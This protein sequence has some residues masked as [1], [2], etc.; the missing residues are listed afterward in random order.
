MLATSLLPGRKGVY[1]DVG[2]YHPSQSSNTYRL[3]LRGWSGVTI[4]PNP[5]A[6]PLFRRRRPHDTHLVSGVAIERGALTYHR[7]AQGNLNTFSADQ[8]A[9]YRGQGATMR[10]Q[11]T[12]ECRPLQQILDEHGVG[13]V[14]LLSVHCEGLDLAVLQ[15]LD[16]SRIRPT[17]I[18]IEDYEAFE[19]LRRG[20]GT[21]AI[22]ALLRPAGYA[23]IG[24]AMF[25]S[26]YVDL[27]ALE[28]RRVGAFNLAAVQL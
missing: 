10:D 27:Q 13:D 16:F 7:F 3:Y 17:A 8:A 20:S 14:D 28:S 9:L 1:V 11:L 18:L 21:S 23:H 2:A 15:S 25:S 22:E 19:R 26:L 6:A 5:D 4:E 24:Q 12:V